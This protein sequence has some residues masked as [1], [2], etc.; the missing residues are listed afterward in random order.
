MLD[1]SYRELYEPI[2]FNENSILRLIALSC[3]LC[4]LKKKSDYSKVQSSRNDIDIMGFDESQK[5]EGV[6]ADDD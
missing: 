6:M 2:G 1:K 4:E 3:N 5:R